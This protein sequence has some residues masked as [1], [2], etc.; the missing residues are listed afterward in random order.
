MSPRPSHAILPL[1]LLAITLPLPLAAQ[2]GPELMR[3]AAAA[4]EERLAGVENVTIVQEMMGMEATLYMEKQV[5]GGTPILV[6]LET[7][8]G[9]MMVQAPEM[10]SS[11]WSAAFQDAWIERTR[12]EGSEMLGGRALHVLV[13]DDL[14][15]LDL[16]QMTGPRGDN[17]QF[18]PERIRYLMDPDDLVLRNMR[19]EGEV[20]LEDGRRV[21][22]E[23]DMQMDDYREVDG[24]LHPFATRIRNSGMMEAMDVDQEEMRAQL[25]EMREQL[26]AM[27]ESQRAILGGM[28][29]EQMERMEAMMGDDGSVEIEMIVR[30]LRVNAGRPGR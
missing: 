15:G 22:F 2:S 13:I 26:E 29:R 23:I 18:L 20:E 10:N 3:R 9:G 11:N 6:P 7:E 12:L 30:E 25:A 8:V 17:V 14:T 16:Q 19:M 5:V 28:L 24:Y 21:P 4:H 27:P 1:L